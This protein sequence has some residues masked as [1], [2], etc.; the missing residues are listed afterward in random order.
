MRQLVAMGPWPRLE[1]GQAGGFDT[2]FDKRTSGGSV[3]EYCETIA[4]ACDLGIRIR[5]AGK[6]RSKKLLFEVYRP[7]ADP[8]HRYSTAWGTLTSLGWRFADTDYANVAIVQGAGE[9]ED[10]TT[11]TVG[12][13]AAT[14]SARRE[15]YVDARDVQPD[16]EKGE[17]AQSASY[18]TRLADRGGKKLLEQLRT[19]VIEF[20][21]EDE[22]LHPGD[23]LRVQIPEMGYRAT[24][25]VA[26]VILQSQADRTTCTTRLGT[27]VWTKY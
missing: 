19:G 1:L 5:L 4:A 21:P 18:L 24:V 22:G 17:T 8:N 11:V 10:R 2:R 14:G 16:E 12:D 13:T 25:R 15:I 20:D 9:G 6:G 7:T 23:V 3:Y 26:A 27:P